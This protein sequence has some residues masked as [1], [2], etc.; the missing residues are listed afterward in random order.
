MYNCSR[1]DNGVTM[2]ENLIN[3]RQEIAA[4][5]LW[6]QRTENIRNSRPIENAC[7]WMTT[8]G[9]TRL[10][11]AVQHAPSLLKS[12]D[13]TT[14]FTNLGIQERKA[15]RLSSSTPDD[16]RISRLTLNP[17]RAPERL[18]LPLSLHN[19][20]L[21]LSGKGVCLADLVVVE[22]AQFNC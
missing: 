1:S 3:V 11:R 21:P 15:K 19:G 16:R 18:P 13:T 12:R 2:A 22:E 14:S 6:W 4:C 17:V 10:F 7:C 20:R 5:P 8:A 9:I